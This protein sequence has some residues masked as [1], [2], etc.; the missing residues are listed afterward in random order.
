MIK[1]IVILVFLMSSICNSQTITEDDIQ[2]TIKKSK[3]VDNSSVFGVRQLRVTSDKLRKVMI[4]TKIKSTPDN[5]TKLSAFSLLDT[6]NKIRYRLADYK[7]YTGAIG[8]PELIPFLKTELFDKKGRPIQ[9]GPTY[10]ILEKDYF[11]EY[12]IDGYTN[13]EMPVNFGTKENPELSV[14]YFG[15]TFFKRFTAELFFTIYVE[16]TNLDYQ[17]LY[18][19]EK[20]GDINFKK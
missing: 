6:K 7:G 12:D 15:E 4:K 2:I 9:Y 11:N 13:F 19:N 10:N 18:K 5:K 1:R 16:N 3:L 20:I 14:V 17:L 8:F